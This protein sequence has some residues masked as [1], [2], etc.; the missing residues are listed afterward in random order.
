[1]QWFKQQKGDKEWKRMSD[2]RTGLQPALT[3]W[4]PLQEKS[5]QIHLCEWHQV[6]W[7]KKLCVMAQII[8][9]FMCESVLMSSW[10]TTMK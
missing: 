9:V 2:L 6:S 5:N 3:T 10:L 7:F 8:W 4:D 1:M